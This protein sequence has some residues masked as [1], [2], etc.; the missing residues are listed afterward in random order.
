MGQLLNNNKA[1]FPAVDQP[2]IERIH[3]ASWSLVLATGSFLVCFAMRVHAEW[4]AFLEWVA[5]LY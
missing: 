3:L 1:K 2:A 4:T 5:V